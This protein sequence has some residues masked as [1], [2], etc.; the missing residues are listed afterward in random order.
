M[1][2]TKGFSDAMKITEPGSW[3]VAQVCLSSLSLGSLLQQKKKK[4]IERVP[5]QRS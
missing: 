1:N 2:F 3:N 4:E 5:E